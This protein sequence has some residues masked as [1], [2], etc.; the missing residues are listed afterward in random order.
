MSNSKLET[1]CVNSLAKVLPNQD[2]DPRYSLKKASAF[3]NEVYSFQVAYRAEQLTKG[4]KIEVESPLA[5][6]INV[7]KVGLSPSELTVYGDHDDYILSD[8]PGLFPD[9]L[10]PLERTGESALPGIW[11]LIWVT[12]DL[13][14]QFSAGDY[15]I[16]IHLLSNDN[17][18]IGSETLQL[19]LL[20][21]SLP[22]QTLI[23]TEWFHTDCIASLYK[24]NVF[25]EEHWRRI[26][27]YIQTAVKQGINMILTPLFTP[28]LDT[29][30]GGERPT[31]QLVGVELG[32]EG[33]RFDF[34][35]LERWI[36]LGNRCGVQYFEFSHLF[37]QWGARSA[38]KIIATVN[39]EQERI[40]GWETDAGGN[41]YSEFLDSLLP[42]LDAFIQKLGLH[43]RVFFHVSDEPS[44]D[45]MESYRNA[46]N[47]LRQH[48]SHYPMFDALSNYAFYEHG[49]VK[50]P[51]VA[52]NHIDT[53]ID[54]EV[55]NLW[56]YYCCSQ[57]K[58][59]SNRFFAF[60]SER[61]RVI[62][63]Q[64]Y[65]FE[66]KGF[67]HW[68]FNFWYS[69]YSRKVLNPFLQTDAD[70]AFPSGD[71]FL[72]YPGEDGP[73][74]SIRMNVFYDA[75]QD[76]R[77]LQMLE[78]LIGRNSVLDLI[79]EDLDTPLT[80]DEYPHDPQWIIKKRE[81]INQLILEEQDATVIIAYDTE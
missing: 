56:T 63:Y 21:A 1:A 15:P 58:K 45:H 35:L 11:S 79:E 14:E 33:Y 28:P 4:I 46:S 69:Q 20:G 77:A 30:V 23:R 6:C 25:E 70:R 39:G 48:L 62:G 18:R 66:I 53:F 3:Q 13:K 19:Q 54:N 31:V 51:V 5:D 29:Q 2:L 8:K 34:T 61:N 43:K 65:K 27:Q 50:M 16:H 75:L 7:R 64:L 76:L 44:L 80:F 10:L 17:E 49:L 72:V 41:E 38:P 71:P 81:Q 24:L 52:S 37:T 73:I 47:K 67:L 32:E 26:E 40:F 42:E 55:K 74:E 68:G 57:Y 36:E 78:G 60:P 22:K 9:P 12:V 59:V